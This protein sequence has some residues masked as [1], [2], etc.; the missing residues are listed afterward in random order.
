MLFHISFS[1]PVLPTLHELF[2]KILDSITIG[3][4]VACIVII[5]PRPGNAV[6]SLVQLQNMMMSVTHL[7]ACLFGKLRCL[8]NRER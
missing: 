8:R 2:R 5:K 6:L 7:E 4:L 3:Q 1:I